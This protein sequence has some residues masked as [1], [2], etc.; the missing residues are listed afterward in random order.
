MIHPSGPHFDGF[1]KEI[2]CF[3]R[4][5]WAVEWQNDCKT[6]LPVLLSFCITVCRFCMVDCEWFHR[7]AKFEIC[8]LAWK[9]SIWCAMFNNIFI[10][11]CNLFHNILAAKWTLFVKCSMYRRRLF[12][13]FSSISVCHVLDCREWFDLL[14]KALASCCLFTYSV[15]EISETL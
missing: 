11:A 2:F 15:F 13:V 4:W 8:L 1:F 6:C 10:A 12:G 5:G 14:C 3:L 9:F 7:N